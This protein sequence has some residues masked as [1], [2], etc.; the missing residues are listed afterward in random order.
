MR[1]CLIT[2]PNGSQIDAEVA[3]TPEL[4]AVG[5]SGRAGLAP[6][7]GMALWWPQPSNDLVITMDGMRFPLDLVWLTLTARRAVSQATH[8]QIVYLVQAATS[9]QFRA[10]KGL[11]ADCVLELAAGEMERLGLISYRIVP[12]SL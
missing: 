2:T 5:L 6:G 1:H 8:G 7:C 11:A 3:D 12:E 4:R 9:G 10:P